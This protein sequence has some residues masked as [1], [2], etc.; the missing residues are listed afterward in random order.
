MGFSGLAV[1]T[2]LYAYQP[3]SLR[4]IVLKSPSH[5]T[6]HRSMICY[7]IHMKGQF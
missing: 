7:N 3:L 1:N 5:P 4:L 2:S 6:H